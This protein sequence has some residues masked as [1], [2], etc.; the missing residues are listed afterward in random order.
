MSMDLEVGIKLCSDRRGEMGCA[1]ARPLSPPRPTKTGAWSREL[2]APQPFS[3]LEAAEIAMLKFDQAELARSV[4]NGAD[5]HS[6]CS[7]LHSRRYGITRN[8]RCV[9]IMAE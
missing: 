7:R 1:K 2:Q 4:D 3:S 6:P 5:T 9:L 8:C